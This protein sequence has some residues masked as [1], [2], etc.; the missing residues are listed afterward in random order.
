MYACYNERAV[1]PTK[2]RKKR[3]ATMWPKFFDRH[4]RA[5][6][7]PHA[8]VKKPRYQDGLPM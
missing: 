3:Q 2:P 4:V 5:D 8:T 7:R 6:T 1:L